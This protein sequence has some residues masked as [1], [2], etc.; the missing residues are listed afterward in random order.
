MTINLLPFSLV[1]QEIAV[2]C[3]RPML[4]Y[5][6]LPSPVLLYIVEIIIIMGGRMIM[7]IM[8]LKLRLK[9]NSHCFKAFST[10]GGK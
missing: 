3:I 10:P 8:G 5:E 9:N 6:V 4:I 7:R 1:L 2:L